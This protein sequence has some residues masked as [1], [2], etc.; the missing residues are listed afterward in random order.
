M[1]SINE[2]IFKF[3]LEHLKETFF[4]CSP[5]FLPIAS[6]NYDNP[7]D[8][9]E[10]CIEHQWEVFVADFIPQM[11]IPR[12]KSYLEF[13]ASL[14]LTKLAE[15]L[16]SEYSDFSETEAE[17]YIVPNR[18]D[19]LRSFLMCYKHKMYSP[20]WVS[21][22]PLEGSHRCA[23]DLEFYLDGDM[24]HIVEKKVRDQT[25]EE[26]FLDEI[27]KLRE[28]RSQLIKPQATIPLQGQY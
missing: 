18:V 1:K 4:Q 25:Y 15:F 19:R 10:V 23:N 11:F 3:R 26:L 5:H 27:L 20:V 24:I 2:A 21:E 28:L 16:A 7:V 17:K 22:S 14:P 9:S 8:Q 13:Y 6:P 12:V